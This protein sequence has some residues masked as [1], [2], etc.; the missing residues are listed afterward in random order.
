MEQS[1]R[2]FLKFMGK[3]FV[4]LGSGLIGLPLGAC[5]SDPAYE[6]LQ[7]LGP[8]LLTDARVEEMT[9]AEVEAFVAEV[10]AAAGDVGPRLPPGQHLVETQPVLGSNPDPRSIESWTFYVK[11]EVEQELEFTWAEFNELDSIEQ[12]SDFHCVTTWSMFDIPWGG[13]RVSTL[14]AIAGLTDKARHV[15][16]DCEQGYTTNMDLEEVLKDNVLIATRRF[17]E[18]LPAKYGGP[19]RGLIPDRYGYKSGKWVIG[20]RVLAVDEPGYWETK[21]YSNTALPWEEDR[22]S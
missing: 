15:V 17:G 11:G 1:K 16:F 19:A 10:D 20:L 12:V 6:D 21:G 22:Y 3:G 8:D 13:V 18:D 5:S 2:R 14:L 4:V 9:A 7:D